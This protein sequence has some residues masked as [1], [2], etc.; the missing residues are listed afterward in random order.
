MQRH[1]GHLLTVSLPRHKHGVADWT[2]HCT[3]Q[4]ARNGASAGSLRLAPIGWVRK[5]VVLAF[6]AD[7]PAQR[8]SMH[9]VHTCSE[10][11]D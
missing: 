4:A 3:H 9:D 5:T 11:M 10:T 8:L 2:L 6:A 1:A 7:T